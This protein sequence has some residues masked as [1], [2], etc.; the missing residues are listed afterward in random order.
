[1]SVEMSDAWAMRGLW[2]AKPCE[3]RANCVESVPYLTRRSRVLASPGGLRHAGVHRG[4]PADAV[5][6]FSRMQLT[7]RA[8]WFIASLFM[9]IGGLLIL[10]A[11]SVILGIFL[12]VLCG[13]F[14]VMG[15]RTPAAPRQRSRRP[16]R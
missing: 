1:M 5:G 2:R 14:Y 9:F 6:T 12:L 3:R 16:R 7:N 10:F 15:V 11:S 13:F 4:G 8:L